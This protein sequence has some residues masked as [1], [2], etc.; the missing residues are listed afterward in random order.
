MIVLSQ[1]PDIYNTLTLE[2]QIRVVGDPLGGA[3]VASLSFSA[4]STVPPDRIHFTDDMYTRSQYEHDI[5]QYLYRRNQHQLIGRYMPG[6]PA[7]RVADSWAWP[8]TR[9][10]CSCQRPNRT[11][12]SW[13]YAPA[14]GRTRSSTR[15]RGTGR[16][17]PT[18]RSTCRCLRVL[19]RGARLGTA[20]MRFSD[21]GPP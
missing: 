12:V 2:G 14:R 4:V 19:G 5:I 20:R 7:A 18:A 1:N 3:E 17:G 15:R 8:R 11:V 13:P 16:T 21:A 9:P 6:T 10:V